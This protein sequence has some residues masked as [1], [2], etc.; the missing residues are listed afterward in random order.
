MTKTRKVSITI[1]IFPDSSAGIYF[2][3]DSQ[4]PTKNMK[5]IL[6]TF[7]NCT[8]VPF[9]GYQYTVKDINRLPKTIKFV[10]D[11][12]EPFGIVKEYHGEL[13]Y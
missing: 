10:R 13:I 8:F 11:I 4:K 2:K 3:Y 5:R 12:K 1:K 7:L 9:M 6:I